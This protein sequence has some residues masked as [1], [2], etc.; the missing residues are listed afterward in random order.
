MLL[1]PSSV[2]SFGTITGS[3]QN[4][5]HER[6]TRAAFACAQGAKSN[7]ECFEPVSLDNLAGRQGTFGVST[8]HKY[9]PA[10]ELRR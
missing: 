10:Y 8:L 7:G 6:I 1:L 2:L 5:E 9:A 3:G 4:A